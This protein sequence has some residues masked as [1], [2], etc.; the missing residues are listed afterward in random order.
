MMSTPSARFMMKKASIPPTH[1]SAVL[2]AARSPLA[3]SPRP[4]TPSTYMPTE[5]RPTM[6]KLN[7]CVIPPSTSKVSGKPVVELGEE[8]LRQATDKLEAALRCVRLGQII[9][10]RWMDRKTHV[11]E[12]SLRPRHM[13][14]VC[15]KQ[16]GVDTR[17]P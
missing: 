12:E 1:S 3:E 9:D 16:D 4:L 14:S 10:R 13:F 15:H 11:L 2:S 5:V 8:C 17:R 6:T 7:T